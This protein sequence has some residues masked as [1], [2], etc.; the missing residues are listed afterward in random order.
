[1]FF[2]FSPG[3]EAP[4]EDIWNTSDI[5]NINAPVATSVGG[6]GGCG[7]GGG[8]V[9]LLPLPI[10]GAPSPPLTLNINPPTPEVAALLR[11]PSMQSES[12][13]SILDTKRRSSQGE[14]VARGPPSV[15]GVFPTAGSSNVSAA[16]AA[17]GGVSS[18]QL[19][20]EA[21][22]AVQLNAVQPIPGQ[23]T[24]GSMEYRE[25]P[26]SPY[27]PPFQSN[28][29]S[30]DPNFHYFGA[31]S[32]HSGKCHT[33]PPYPGNNSL[34]GNNC[35]PTSPCTGDPTTPYN[36]NGV[37]NHGQEGQAVH[38]GHLPH[39]PPFQRSD[40]QIQDESFHRYLI[41]GHLLYDLLKKPK[42][43]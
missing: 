36:G 39:H 31:A 8:V 6:V 42:I 30:P 41:I 10:R 18:R 15:F 26:I 24:P 11:T 22:A 35:N 27:S 14:R 9:N 13:V 5:Q 12:S 2:L 32:S 43:L 3:Y 23:N 28:P 7:G 19:S 38:T 16:A 34:S 40:S 33:S 29:T 37:Q 17:P 1:M 21:A 4:A 25:Q 20:L